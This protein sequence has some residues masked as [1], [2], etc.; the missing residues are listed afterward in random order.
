MPYIT[1]TAI[2]LRE[3]LSVFGGDYP[4]DDGTCIRDYIHV[5]DLARAHVVALQRL[6]EDQQETNFEIFNLGTGKGSSVLEVIES[7]ERVSG[8]K[9]KY[10]ITD[11]RSG[12]V[13]A[14]YAETSKAKNI[15]GWKTELSL[16]DAMASAW[17]WEQRI[18]A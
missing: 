13:V 18:R 7:F 6:F 3:Q 11:R 16:D 14:A 12:D 4:T 5:V 15:L 10:Q 1:Q 9:L 17:K 8:E 2:G